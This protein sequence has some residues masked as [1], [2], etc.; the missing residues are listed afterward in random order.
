[1]AVPRRSGHGGEAEEGILDRIR[2][3]ERPER[4]EYRLTANGRRPGGHPRRPAALGRQVHQRKAT[5]DHAPKIGRAASDRGVV[6][7]GA[8]VVREDELE[9]VPGRGMKSG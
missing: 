8:D 7:Q 9:S 3:S 4:Y 5:S 2:Y 1:V 6:A